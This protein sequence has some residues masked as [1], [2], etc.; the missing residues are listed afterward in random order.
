MKAIYRILEN[1]SRFG[2][3]KV[4]SLY[5]SH[6]RAFVVSNEDPEGY[7][8]LQLIIPAITGAQA[9]KTWAWQKGAFSGKGYGMQVIPQK[10]DMVW[11]TFEFGRLTNPIWDYGHFS[12]GEK[13][14]E[15]INVK[16]FWFKTPSGHLVELDDET[17]EV[18]I[19]NSA[20]LKIVSSK[21]CISLIRND[22]K[23]SIGKLDASDEPTVLGNK[24]EEVLNGIL[25]EL[26]NLIKSLS[27]LSRKQSGVSM[28]PLG[29]LKA[30]FI[31]FSTSLTSI[32]SKVKEIESKVEGTKSKNVTVDG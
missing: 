5:Y 2:L 1:I 32:E 20:G 18:R 25:G 16:N 22:K 3:E 28:G 21:D 11:V 14:K 6:Y 27:S 9:L 31:T 15:L 23:I 17:G 13:P 8:R 10:G 26:K 29:P 30:G 4:F 12:K 19:T 24:N 7:G